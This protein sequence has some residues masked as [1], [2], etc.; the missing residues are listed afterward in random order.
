MGKV[1]KV[2]F[3]KKRDIKPS[4]VN[5]VAKNLFIVNIAFLIVCFGLMF[6]LKW[7]S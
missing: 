3:K 1:I 6:L 7:V 2:N 5:E 4:K